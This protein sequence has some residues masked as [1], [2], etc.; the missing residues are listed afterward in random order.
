MDFES[1]AAENKYIRGFICRALVNCARN[2][3]PVK[4]IADALVARGTIIVPDISKQ[5][6]YLIKGGYVCFV[7][8]MITAYS[9]YAE[10][11]VIE[12]TKEGIDLI[13]GTIEDDGVDI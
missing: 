4:Q 12:L 7:D 10:D 6:D 9:K 8:Q 5:V 13:E 11:G 2:R 3:A 1:M